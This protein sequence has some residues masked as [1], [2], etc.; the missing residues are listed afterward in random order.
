MTHPLKQ[1][2]DDFLS[3]ARAALPVGQDVQFHQD[4]VGVLTGTVKEVRFDGVKVIIVEYGFHSTIPF[5]AI[6]RAQQ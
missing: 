5:N 6:L 2:M 4:G 3:S 1:A